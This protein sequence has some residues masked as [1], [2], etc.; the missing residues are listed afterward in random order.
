[1]LPLEIL[2]DEDSQNFRG[3]QH[4]SKYKTIRF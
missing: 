1:M 3:V 4:T 2:D